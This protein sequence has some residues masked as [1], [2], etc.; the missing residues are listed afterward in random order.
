MVGTKE[1]RSVT[2]G[3]LEVVKTAGAIPR[4]SVGD[5]VV[6]FVFLQ[7]KNT[8]VSPD[9][10]IYSNYFK[11]K[12]WK[13]LIYIWDMKSTRPLSEVQKLTRSEQISST[14][15]CLCDALK[16]LE[17]SSVPNTFELKLKMVATVEALVEKLQRLHGVD[18]SF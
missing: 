17:E 8:K 16:S 7:G 5:N 10:K 12:F 3:D 18:D 4:T 14:L 15:S 6:M 13:I 11:I 9:K 2:F 1:Y